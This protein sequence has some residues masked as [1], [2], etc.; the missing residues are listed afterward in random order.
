L[1]AKGLLLAD[2]IVGKIIALADNVIA[3]KDGEIVD[4]G[5]PQDLLAGDGY[6]SKLGM[7]MPSEIQAGELWENEESKP[8][9]ERTKEKTSTS[10]DQQRKKGELSVYMFYFANSGYFFLFGNL[11][12]IVAWMFLT[13]FSSKSTS[14]LIMR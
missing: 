12:S 13:E 10:I 1:I 14:S 3:L 6:V 2:S 9:V 5:K 4:T 7:K 11:L 8:P